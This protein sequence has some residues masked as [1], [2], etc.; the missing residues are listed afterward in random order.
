MKRTLITLV[1]VLGLLTLTAGGALGQVEKLTISPVVG[2]MLAIAG[3]GSGANLSFTAG[4]SGFDFQ[5]GTSTGS[6]GNG[7]LG[8]ISGTYSFTSASITPEGGGQQ[9][10]LTGSGTLTINDGAGHNLTGTVTSLEKV[11][12]NAAGNSLPI[13]DLMVVNL[14]GM[15]YSGLQQDLLNLVHFDAG[16]AVLDLTATVAPSANLTTMSGSTFTGSETYSGD[17]GDIRITPLPGS[18]LLLGTGLLGLALLGFRRKGT[19]FQP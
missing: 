1:C 16:Q 12:T 3:T 7:D 8:T 2:G 4:S 14:T 10:P 15:A 18:A 19:A 11:E 5:V 6:T 13:N 9:A 17:I